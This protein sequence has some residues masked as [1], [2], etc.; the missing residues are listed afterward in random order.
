MQSLHTPIGWLKIAEQDGKLVDISITKH[1]PVVQQ[2]SALEQKTS[3]QLARYFQHQNR[4]FSLPLGLEGTDFQL[5]V[6]RALSKIPF[7]Q[8]R[9]YG[10]LARELK[11][12]P[13]AVGNACRANP[14]PII[15][16]C[17][18]VISANG[19]GGYAGKTSGP[20]LERKRWLLLHEGLLY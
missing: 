7:G 9:T 12:S 17:H 16:P 13:R 20:I 2:P 18:R 10:Q 14:L 15:V 19:I 11:S 4:R 8:V 1:K 6:W 5:R 3:T